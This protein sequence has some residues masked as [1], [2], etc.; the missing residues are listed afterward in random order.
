MCVCVCVCVCVCMCVCVCVCVCVC[1]TL[2]V[3]V[4][5]TVFTS[6]QQSTRGAVTGVGESM[7]AFASA[8]APIVGTPLFAWSES[9]GEFSETIITCGW[10]LCSAYPYKMFSI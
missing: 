10:F 8:V 1:G 6:F 4:E 7:C 2:H 9:T 5:I 3:G